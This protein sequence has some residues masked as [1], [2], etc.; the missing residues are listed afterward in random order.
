MTETGKAA[1]ARAAM[2]AV[3]PLVELFLELGITSPEAESL[4]RGVFVHT[5]RKW[6]ASQSRSGEAPS[7]VRVSLVT[8]VHRN[9]VRRI[10]AEPPRIAAA[11]EQKGG[12]A[13]RLLEAWHSDPVYLDSSGKPRDLPEKDHEPSFYSLAAAYLPGAAPGVV[14]EELRRAGLVQLLAE[15]RVRV[16]SRA[17]KTQGISVGN[18]GEMGS[19]ARELLE[20]L[21][22]NLRNPA[23]PLFCE[24]IRVLNIDASR[25]SAVRNVIN[26]RASTFLT[27]ME[28]E[29]AIEAEKASPGGRRDRIKVGLTVFETERPAKRQE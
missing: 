18:V 22:H 3:E 28:N 17:Y 21:R 14:L 7:D 4:L 5:A 6:L 25:L 19:R 16:R 24:A 23:S 13:S 1:L 29:L 15:H 20:T 8:G 9:F 10:L 26:R 2:S 11:R 12:G 27:A